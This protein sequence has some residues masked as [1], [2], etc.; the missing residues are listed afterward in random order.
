MDVPRDEVVAFALYTQDRGVLKLTAQLLSAEAGRSARG[1]AG[2]SARRRVERGGEDSGALSR[3]GARIFAIEKWDATKDVPI[4]CGTATKA[5][6]EG[7]IRRDPV[8]KDVIVVANMSCNSSRTDGLR[9]EIIEH[10][11][12]QNPDLL[13]FAGDQTY[14]HTEHTAGWIEFGLQF[15]DVMRDRPTIS[16]PDDHD[17]GHPNLWG[18]NGKRVAAAGRRGRRITSIPSNT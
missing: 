9:P 17:V 16:I 14:R 4:A 11:K 8:D 2:V 3:A 15:R 1:A 18:E 10:L 5:M 12:A 6:F 7:L 13:F